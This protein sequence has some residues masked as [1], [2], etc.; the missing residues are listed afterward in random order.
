MTGSGNI[1]WPGTTF[2]I[3]LKE[4]VSMKRWQKLLAIGTALLLATPALLAG[5]VKKAVPTG[6]PLRIMTYNIHHGAGTDGK[7]DLD[8][9]TKTIAR[10]KPDMV[11]LN[12]I[13]GEGPAFGNQVDAI[14]M[15]LQKKTGKKWYAA[16]GKNLEISNGHYGNAIFSSYPILKQENR[17]LDRI[18]DSNEQRGCL[19]TQVKIGTKPVNFFTTHLAYQGNA[20]T[21]RSY[22]VATIM[23]WMKES[24]GYNFLAGDMN[25]LHGEAAMQ[26]IKTSCL[27]SW[28]VSHKSPEKG[29]S[30]SAT[31]PEIRIDYIFSK[32]TSTLSVSTCYVPGDKLVELASDHRPVV[33]AFRLR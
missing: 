26:T 11:S 10:E 21:E 12:E 14:K 1:S 23:D 31:Q 4:M 17:W 29:F 30:F 16:F 28:A 8:R 25:A 24:H 9:I 18:P 13:Y 22:S 32:D 2:N 19:K 3:P 5:S 20:T 7:I 15:L 27:D 6:T 33:A